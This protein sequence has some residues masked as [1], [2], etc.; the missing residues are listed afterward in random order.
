M[1]KFENKHKVLHVVCGKDNCGVIVEK[2]PEG[3]WD[4]DVDGM[5]KRNGEWR[6]PEKRKELK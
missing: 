4:R 1:P 6:K 5:L 3:K 2:L